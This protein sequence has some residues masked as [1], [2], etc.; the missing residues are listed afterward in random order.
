MTYND[1]NKENGIV[2]L[3][4][5]KIKNSKQEVEVNPRDIMH[6]NSKLARLPHRINGK[7]FFG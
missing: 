5:T 3:P 4:G 7:L 1:L 2:H 6:I